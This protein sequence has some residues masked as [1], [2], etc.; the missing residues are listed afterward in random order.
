MEMGKERLRYLK[1]CEI[2]RACD[3]LPPLMEDF[4]DND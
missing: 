2:A 3:N 1:A 4:I